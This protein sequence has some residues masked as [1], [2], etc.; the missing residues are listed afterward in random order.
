[1]YHCFTFNHAVRLA[2]NTEEYVG[3]NKEEWAS[4]FEKV[5]DSGDLEKNLSFG[6]EYFCFYI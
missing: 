1:M 6:I 2:M 5:F 4:K 3:F